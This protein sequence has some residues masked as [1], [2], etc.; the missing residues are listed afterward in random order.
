MSSLS[1]RASYMASLRQ[2]KPLPHIPDRARKIAAF[3]EIRK[4]VTDPPAL[5]AKYR[6]K[7]RQQGLT[8]FTG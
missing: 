7:I 8:P 4:E 1:I 3:Q 5:W 6:E 2:T